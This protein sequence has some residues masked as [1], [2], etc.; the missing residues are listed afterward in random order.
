MNVRNRIAH[1]YARTGLAGQ[2]LRDRAGNTLAMIAA[3]L[4][5]LLALVGGGIDMGRSYLSQSR[6]QQACDA[7]VLAA[8]KKLG[9]QIVLTGTVP[10]EV[11]TIGDKFFNQNFRS[12]SYGTKNRTFAMTLEADYA[13]SGVAHIDVPTSIMYLFGHTNVAID[14]KCAAKLNFSNTDIMFVLDTTGSMAEKNPSD[15]EPRLAAMKQVV[16]NFHAQ[17]EGS[18]T[19]GTVVRYGFVPYST[20]VNVGGLLKDDWVVSKWDYQSR[21]QIKVGTT[22]GTTSYE[23]NRKQVSGV[24]SASQRQSGSDFAAV[25]NPPVTV[26][27]PG[28]TTV[29][30]NENVVVIPPSTTTTPGYYS[31]NGSGPADSYTDDRTSGT[32]TTEPYAGPPAGTRTITPYTRVLKG[33]NYWVS[34]NGSKCEVS[35][36]D[37]D[38]Y[39]ETY[40]I[41]TDPTESPV[42]NWRYQQLGADVSLW[43]SQSNGCIEERDT[44]EINDY[45]NV[46]LTRALDLDIDLVPTGDVKTKWRPMYGNLV[47]ARSLLWNGTGSFTQ[48]TVTTD[49]DFIN[50]ASGGFAACPALAKKLNAMT[51]GDVTTY[52]GTLNPNGAT[53]HDIGMIWGGRLLSPTGLFASENAD[54]AGKPTSRHLIF[55]T[56]GLTA[57]LDV[58]YST[59]GLEPLDKRRWSEGSALSLTQVVEKRFGVAC[60]EVKKRNITVWVIGF[61]TTLNP[62][63]TDCAGAGHSFEATNAAELNDV[64]SKIAAQMG[65][66]RIAK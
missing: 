46:D 25:W 45:A 56:D 33:R 66:L 6:L 48:A 8:R 18:K 42:F 55:L 23:M 44:Y 57:P 26:T 50:P 53:Y 65:D 7:G 13:I 29:D 22:K 16:K 28:S 12:G 11:Q 38:D 9:S 37:Y 43:R 41:Y 39:T 17:I 24:I 61:G 4:F 19:P 32:E 64:F 59:Y 1:I 60:E 31:C 40:D 52:L 34:L 5:P 20:N 10:A 30:A 35:Y 62:V 51:A 36:V 27:D 21:E 15:T 14:V 49:Q 47:F 63:M 54:A 58:S 3:G 2:L